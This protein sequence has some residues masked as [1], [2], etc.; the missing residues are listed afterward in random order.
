MTKF[1]V[2]DRVRLVGEEWASYK[3]RDWSGEFDPDAV[4]I[5]DEV[6]EYGIVSAGNAGV[7]FSGY[8]GEMLVGYEVELIEDEQ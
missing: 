1:K 4:Y 6:D 3:G 8:I 2:G 7:I 5:V